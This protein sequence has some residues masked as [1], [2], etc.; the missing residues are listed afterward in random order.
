MIMELRVQAFR[1]ILAQSGS[2]FD[3]QTPRKLVNRLAFDAQKIQAVI[4]L[5]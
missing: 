5:I 1:N 4:F 2:Y 3:G